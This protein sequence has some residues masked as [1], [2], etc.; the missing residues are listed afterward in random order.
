MIGRDFTHLGT[1]AGIY[2]QYGDGYG[3]PYKGDIKPVFIDSSTMAIIDQDQGIHVQ[4]L[5]GRSYYICPPPTA[6]DLAIAAAQ[7]D[8]SESDEDSSVKEA[9]ED[10]RYK[11][12]IPAAICTLPHMSTHVAVA[13]INN[14]I[15]ICH[16]T[17]WSTD[18]LIG[19]IGSAMGKFARISAITS[20]ECEGEMLYVVAELGNQR[21]QIVDEECL[22][23]VNTGG[24][25]I[26]P[27]QFRD[28]VAVTSFMDTSN[29]KERV[30]TAGEASLERLTTH[31][32]VS[33]MGGG[34]RRSSGF[35]QSPKNA[36]G[37]RLSINTG[38]TASSPTI[39]NRS[40]SGT[41][42]FPSSPSSPTAG[43]PMGK[44]SSS[45]VGGNTPTSPGGLFRQTSGIK[46]IAGRRTTVAAP[47][48]GFGDIKPHWYHGMCKL[49]DLKSRIG[50]KMEVG[51]Y[52]LGKRQDDHLLYDFLFVVQ[53]NPEAAATF[54]H[55]VFRVRD[56]DGRIFNCT[57]ELNNCADPTGY[58]CIWEAMCS[59]YSKYLRH[60]ADPR[61]FVSIAVADVG[62]RRVQLFK[63]YFTV[64]PDLYVP[65]LDFFA[66]IGG[67]NCRVL[68]LHEP[69]AVA[70]TATGELVICDCGIRKVVI[71][72]K[73]LTVIASIAIGFELSKNNF[74]NTP[75]NSRPGTRAGRSRPG[76]RSGRIDLGHPPRE[77]NATHDYKASSVNI[78]EDG[79]IAIGFKCGGLLVF[80]PFKTFKMGWLEKLPVSLFLLVME[81]CT[82]GDI[83]A[84][85][86]CCKYLH[87]FTRDRR[88]LWALSGMRPHYCQR[89]VYS[90][91]KWA[92]TPEGLPVL[93]Y[94]IPC[95]DKDGNQVCTRFLELKCEYPHCA[96]PHTLPVYD[97]KF[98]TKAK[99]SA[100]D[101]V[102]FYGIITFIFSSTFLWKNEVYIN[103]LFQF[104]CT[105]RK[106][107][108][109]VVSLGEHCC[110][111]L[112]TFIE[113]IRF[114]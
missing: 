82:Y 51:R 113:L 27:G 32:P 102:S 45:P 93:S 71:L 101:L 73:Q 58:G 7:E 70:Y 99:E 84:L 16:K 86:N 6:E 21:I 59:R 15:K 48:A 108:V 97:Y 9:V 31:M 49:R 75:A 76:T 39:G 85:R 50:R 5:G 36:T 18:N 87:D 89:A 46:R 78:S 12:I 68:K 4:R 100:I 53:Y 106:T 30:K 2:S 44:L 79:K 112:I 104:Y 67:S 77:K 90:Y 66:I 17:D 40:R 88:A 92:K 10:I 13:D 42:N 94:S 20:F 23:V 111:F 60:D 64:V 38:S 56:S 80:K 52:A 26:L 3:Y 91:I 22:P 43:S 54:E 55:V 98:L 8:E 72:S 28:P 103:E 105:V 29:V 109:R 65:A 81:Y 96:K 110:P 34:A 69:T 24:T 14:F 57:D 107:C 74:R 47:I 33:P 1:T 83:V 61:P 41:F 63:Y 19:G 62:N 114:P 37:G 25:G 11:E 95:V 35:N